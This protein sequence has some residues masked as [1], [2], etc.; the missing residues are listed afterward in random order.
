VADHAD[1]VAGLA[2]FDRDQ[3]V[4]PAFEAEDFTA[5]DDPAQVTAIAAA[6]RG[7]PV[8]LSAGDIAEIV[9]FLGSLSDPVA[10][11][12]RLGIPTSVPSGLALP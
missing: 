5:M 3:V 9:A 4:L 2:R 1:P 11:T 12:G 10:V 8:S 6:V 7:D